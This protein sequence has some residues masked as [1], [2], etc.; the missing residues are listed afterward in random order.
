MIKSIFY[1]IQILVCL[2]SLFYSQN[3]DKTVV[4]TWSSLL[5]FSDLVL[6]LKTTIQETKAYYVRAIIIFSIS[7]FVVHF[8][9]YIDILL[10]KE[11]YD[12]YGFYSNVFTCSKTA[13]L[14]L[15]GFA[16]LGLSYTINLKYLSRNIKHDYRHRITSEVNEISYKAAVIFLVVLFGLFVSINGEQYL[17]GNYSQE[18]I[19]NNSG[20]LKAYVPL[21]IDSLVISCVILKSLYWKNRNIRISVLKYLKSF[22][23][24]FYS[25]MIMYW[26]FIAFSGDRGPIIFS[27]MTIV[28]GILFT[29]KYQP[30]LSIVVSLFIG[31][32]LI[33]SILGTS[34]RNNGNDN[35][36]SSESIS[37]YVFIISDRETILPLT[38]ELAGSNVC[39]LCA[40]DYVPESIPHTYGYFSLNGI[41][42]AIP[43]WGSMM[44]QLGLGSSIISSS[45]LIDIILNNGDKSISGNGSSIIAD[46]Y[47]EGGAIGIIIG[48]LLFGLLFAFIDTSVFCKNW[49]KNSLV[50][51]VTLFVIFEKSIY[52]PRSMATAEVRH[53]FFVFIIL[54]LIIKIFGSKNNA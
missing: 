22:G 14:S 38:S 20:T 13:I 2:V 42:T 40:V 37:E 46:L 18:M 50:T 31:A 35:K 54:Y 16:V 33:V 29:T 15:L 48:M 19:E 9:T 44:A 25:I 21:L 23:I 49:T 12:Q 47:I 4:L 7:F 30:R 24:L 11:I 5:A 53:I 10:G 28:A 3:W 17:S 36:F 8:Q 32:A 45:N 34:R 27:A 1:L 52:I 41:L 51:I 39:A 26:I 43:F 6:I